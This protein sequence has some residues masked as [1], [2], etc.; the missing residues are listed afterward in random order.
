M[1]DVMVLAM[2]MAYIGFSGIVASQLD[3]LGQME[4]PSRDLTILTTNATSLQPGFYLF[5]TYSVLALFFAEILTGAKK[6]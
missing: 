2:F 1:A 5:L 4:T 6:L 3:P